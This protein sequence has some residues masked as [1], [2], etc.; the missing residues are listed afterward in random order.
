MEYNVVLVRYGE[1]ILKGN[2]R[3]MFERKLVDNMKK[4]LDG[5]DVK[6]IFS[7]ARIFV[8]P[9]DTSRVDIIIKKLIKPE[10]KLP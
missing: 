10:I 9:T 2:N 7:Q 1:I 8:K 4:A 5:E 3:S 6:I